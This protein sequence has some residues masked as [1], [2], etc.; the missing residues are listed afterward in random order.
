MPE[1]PTEKTMVR[2][3]AA[4]DRDKQRRQRAAL[5]NSGQVVRHAIIAQLKDGS[6]HVLGQGMNIDDLGRAMLAASHAVINAGISEDEIKLR[7]QGVGV[8][9]NPGPDGDLHRP[10]APRH[11]IADDGTLIPPEGESFIR[12]G[13]CQNPSWYIT[14]TDDGHPGSNICIRCGNNLR[15]R[16][17]LRRE[18]RA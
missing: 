11:H 9:L 1:N 8:T 7:A 2:L 4:G 15:W 17:M 13:E 6:Y 18:G 5:M 10:I 12:C 16:R 14:H 3:Q